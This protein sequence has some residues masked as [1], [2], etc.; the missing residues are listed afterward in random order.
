MNSKPGKSHWSNINEKGA[1]I[2]MRTMFFIYQYLGRFPFY[3]V[4]FP[5][6]AYFFVANGD[7]RRASLQYL[8]RLK[9][10]GVNFRRRPMLWLSYCQ[11]Y[12]FGSSLLDKLAV[13]VGKIKVTDLKF[14]GYD[15]FDACNEKQQGTLIIGSHLGNIEVCRALASQK[16]ALRINVLVHTKHAAKFNSMLKSVA[17]DSDVNLIQVT[18]IGPGTAMLLNEKL[19][20]GEHIVIAGDRTPVNG[21]NTAKVEFFGESAD[22]PKGP[23]IL[24]SILKCPVFTMFCLKEG[25]QYGFYVDK[26]FDQV[27]LS[28]KQR[29]EALQQYLQ[30]YAKQLENYCI[31]A[32]LQWYNFY[33]FWND[34][35]EQK[36]QQIDDGRAN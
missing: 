29:D 26:L 35:H 5:V 16:T 11:F 18:D 22:F 14:Y 12:N 27:T 24:A 17:G 28:R 32:P 33:P 23:L 2:G 19:M 1:L 3:V 36:Q 34:L 6:I 20:R 7:A 8:T 21:K 15:A 10:A 9:N 25:S 31:K 30:A 13:W 4:L